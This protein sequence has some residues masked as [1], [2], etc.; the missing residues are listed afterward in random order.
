[1]KHSKLGE[2]HLLKLEIGDEVVK[3][4]LEFARAQ[5]IRAATVSA[6]G[7]MTD[8]VIGYFNVT[9]KDYDR[10]ELSGN[11]EIVSLLGNIARK[12]G[13]PLLHAH[14]VL[15]SSLGV[16]GVHLFGGTICAT[17]EFVITPLEGELKRSIDPATNLPLWDLR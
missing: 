3:S 4:V 1:M 7:A 5:E 16:Y 12:D 2:V 14:V 15:G 13:E 17:G 9:S 11:Y 8:P 10:H 6:I